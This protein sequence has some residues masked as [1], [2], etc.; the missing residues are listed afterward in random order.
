VLP[1]GC[2]DMYVSADRPQVD[3]GISISGQFA[4]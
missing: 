3:D 2:F 4:S 1:C